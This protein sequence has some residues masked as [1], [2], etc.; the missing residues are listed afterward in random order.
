MRVHSVE[1]NIVGASSMGTG[2]LAVSS[3][4]GALPFLSASVTDIPQEEIAQ[5]IR[6]VAQM[7]QPFAVSDTGVTS[8]RMTSVRKSD[9]SVQR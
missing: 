2:D 9:P 8:A 4:A 5:G 7:P 3:M 6:T 1:S